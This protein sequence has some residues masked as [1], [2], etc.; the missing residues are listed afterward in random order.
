MHLTGTDRRLSS[1]PGSINIF[2]DPRD[3]LT[4]TARAGVS[5][6]A[7][8][9]A[10]VIGASCLDAV[11]ASVRLAN[12]VSDVPANGNPPSRENTAAA[13]AAAV[14]FRS[15]NRLELPDGD[16]A[17]DGGLTHR[18]TTGQRPA[19]GDSEIGALVHGGQDVVKAARVGAIGS[20]RLRRARA[21]LR[22]EQLHDSVL[23]T[24]RRPLAR[25]GAVKAGVAGIAGDRDRARVHGHGCRRRDEGESPDEHDEAGYEQNPELPLPPL[26]F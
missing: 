11:D 21:A 17:R 10:A 25:H 4:P 19:L 24:R 12:A 6:R 20:D 15:R 2:A 26:L 5:N 13:C 23:L 1:T 16:R 18:A 7:S 3:R 9:G 8:S 14:F 22:P